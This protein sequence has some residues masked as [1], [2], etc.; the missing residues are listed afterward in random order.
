ML[1]RPAAQPPGGSHIKM[2]GCPGAQP[3]AV[4]KL[5]VGSA[6]E[7]LYSLSLRHSVNKN[8]RR[9]ISA[10]KIQLSQRMT[11]ERG[12]EPPLFRT[13][14][15]FPYDFEIA[16]FN[17]NWTENLQVFFFSAVLMFALS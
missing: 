14:F 16:G 15:R 1:K 7:L 8:I 3:A 6:P 12:F 9:V 4:R 17:C 5:S 10:Y 2:T 11:I 13:I